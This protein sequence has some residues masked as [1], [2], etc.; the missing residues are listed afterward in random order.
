MERWVC[1]NGVFCP[2]NTAKVSVTDRGF[3]FGEG[4]F[5][6]LRVSAGHCEF[7]SSH[8]KRLEEQAHFLGLHYPSIQLE[9]LQELIER[10]Q[11]MEGIWRLK[12]ILTADHLLLTLQPYQAFSADS[13]RLCLFPQPFERPLAHIKSLAYLDYLYIRNY[14][15]QQGFDDSVT[16]TK[17]G[18]LLETSSANLFWIDDKGCGIPDRQLPYLKGTFLRA[19]LDHLALPVNEAHMTVQQLSPEASL[20]ICNALM[21]VRP[22]TAIGHDSFERHQGREALL[23]QAVDQALDKDRMGTRAR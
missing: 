4:I 20:Y 17:E 9:W 6:T 18:Y 21:H 16:Q 19:I 10:N 5:T 7:L 14:A 15:R 22:V 2:E 11:A 23:Q 1:L 8:L 3:L 13:Y 12:M